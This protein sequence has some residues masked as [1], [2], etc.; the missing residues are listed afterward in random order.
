VISVISVQ[1]IKCLQDSEGGFKQTSIRESLSMSDN[2][3]R[4]YEG[5]SKQSTLNGLYDK[6]HC[7]GL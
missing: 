4:N 5:G 2:S 3:N 6:Q 1:G 7:K